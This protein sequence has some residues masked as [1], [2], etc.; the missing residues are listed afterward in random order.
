MVGVSISGG[1]AWGCKDRG[2]GQIELQRIQGSSK[3]ASGEVRLLGKMAPPSV[4]IPA[5]PPCWA[6]DSSRLDPRVP[7]GDAD[8][9]RTR[10]D[11]VDQETRERAERGCGVVCC[12][13]C[14]RG[15]ARD[16]GECIRR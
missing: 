8:R 10:G 15:G 4:M 7:T 1:G 11:Q 9:N 12:V 3:V 5:R 2:G 16:L 13:C 14:G 6:L